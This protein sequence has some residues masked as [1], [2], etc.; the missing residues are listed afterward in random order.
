MK[1]YTIDKK[2][3]P[4]GYRY[5]RYRSFFDGHVG[6]WHGGLG[7]YRHDGELI[8]AEEYAKIEGEAH[9]EIIRALIGNTNEETS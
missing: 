4:G 1:I 2:I 6:Q 8:S 5:F 3:E 7:V 9:A